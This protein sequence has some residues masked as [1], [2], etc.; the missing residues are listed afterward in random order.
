MNPETPPVLKPAARL[1]RYVA[2][3]REAFAATAALPRPWLLML[4]VVVVAGLSS[5]FLADFLVEF[6]RAE[7]IKAMVE[8]GGMSALEAGKMMDQGRGFQRVVILLGAPLGA[9]LT[10]VVS[11]LIY[12]GLGNLL[13]GERAAYKA[14]LEV[15]AVG[16]LVRA[17]GGLLRVPLILRTEDAQASLGLGAFVEAGSR[18]QA[19]LA[20]IDPFAIWAVGL[21]ALGLASVYGV[22]VRRAGWLAAG[23]WGA[24]IAVQ[25]ALAWIQGGGVGF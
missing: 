2:A 3:P 17:F 14:V 12:W 21:I 13:F 24:G 8:R 18:L 11:A 7:A 19:V 23:L 16:A 15:V 6:G 1:R 5:W 9:L 4:L 10:M 25:G 22:S 20:P